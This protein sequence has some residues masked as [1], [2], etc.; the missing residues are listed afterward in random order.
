[1]AETFATPGKRMATAADNDDDNN[2]D[3]FGT[4]EEKKAVGEHAAKVKGSCK[5]KEYD[6]IILPCNFFSFIDGGG[7]QKIQLFLNSSTSSAKVW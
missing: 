2:V 1:M 7:G 6:C 5:K 3:L 4:K